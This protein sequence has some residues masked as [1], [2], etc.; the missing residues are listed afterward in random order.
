[1][2]FNAERGGEA[3]F[4]FN[5][6]NAFG[7]RSIFRGSP[8]AFAYHPSARQ[9]RFGTKIWVSRRYGKSSSSAILRR[10]LQRLQYRL[11]SSYQV[12]KVILQVQRTHFVCSFIQKYFVGQGSTGNSD[13]TSTQ[14]RFLQIKA[15]RPFSWKKYTSG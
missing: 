13:V 9:M 7:V 1:M 5:V 3:S 14:D 10:S 4:R 6:Y 8:G 15:Q 2:K 12:L 11:A